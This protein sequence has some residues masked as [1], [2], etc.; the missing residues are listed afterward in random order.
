MAGSGEV[1]RPWF[2]YVIECDDGRLYTGVTNDLVARFATHVSG[3]GAAFTRMNK[4]LRLLASRTYPSRSVALKAEALLK[5]QT[6]EFKIAWLAANPAP[7][8]VA[9]LCD[10]SP[11]AGGGGAAAPTRRPPSRRSR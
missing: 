2:L 4:P 11:D 9:R 1:G 7:H 6:R 10:R 5:K 8:E 3:K